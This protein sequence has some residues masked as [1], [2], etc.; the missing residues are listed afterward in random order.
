VNLDEF[1]ARFGKGQSPHMLCGEAGALGEDV[2]ASFPRH[3]PVDEGEF[4]MQP[5]PLNN[6]S[7]HLLKALDHHS[8]LA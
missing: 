2:E 3:S 8:S 6:L 1:V 7:I 5:P 4:L